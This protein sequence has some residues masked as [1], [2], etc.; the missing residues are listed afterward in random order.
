MEIN[1]NILYLL[2]GT[3]LLGIDKRFCPHPLTLPQQTRKKYRR[4]CVSSVIRQVA[5]MV[6]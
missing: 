2:D 4:P 3:T 5:P 6:P 1:K